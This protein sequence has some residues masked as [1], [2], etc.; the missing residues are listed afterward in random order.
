MDDNDKDGS[1]NGDDVNHKKE[2]DNSSTDDDDHHHHEDLSNGIGSHALYSLEGVVADSQIG[3]DRLW[4]RPVL[5]ILSA[6]A[7]PLSPSSPIPSDQF[8][9]TNNSSNHVHSI[10]SMKSHQ[11]YS[12]NTNSTTSTN[13]RLVVASSIDEEEEED[14]DDGN[15][16][17]M[18]RNYCED[19]D[20]LHTPEGK[21]QLVQIHLDNPSDEPLF[22]HHQHQ[23]QQQGSH[24]DN[25]DLHSPSQSH[26]R[27]SSSPSRSSSPRSRQST[28]FRNG[29][30][31]AVVSSSILDVVG[32]VVEKK[33]KVGDS[34]RKRK[35]GMIQSNKIEQYFP[36]KNP[37]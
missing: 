32:A 4:K 28:P 14:D 5:S 16:T 21:R 19:E 18:I 7:P 20:D 9:N 13:S 6:H 1:Q 2:Y 15:T 29:L 12:V 11:Q 25:Y 3:E 27:R 31:A 34:P 17:A 24:Q 36:K 35:H 33:G 22:N 23:H 26:L 8:A 10:S 37:N 30:K